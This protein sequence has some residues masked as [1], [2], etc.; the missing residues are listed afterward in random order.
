MNFKDVKIK[1]F[2]DTISEVSLQNDEGHTIHGQHNRSPEL[3]LSRKYLEYKLENLQLQLTFGVIFCRTT[4]Y[5]DTV[6]RLV[7]LKEHKVWRVYI[8]VYHSQAKDCKF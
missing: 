5:L 2:S 7:F 1:L 4:S 6:H 3:G 8:H